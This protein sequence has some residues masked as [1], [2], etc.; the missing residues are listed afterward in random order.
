MCVV[1]YVIIEIKIN[2]FK[3][4]YYVALFESQRIIFHRQQALLLNA[5][6]AKLKTFNKPTGRCDYFTIQA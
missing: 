5:L 4:G 3:L 1:F 6:T 2:S